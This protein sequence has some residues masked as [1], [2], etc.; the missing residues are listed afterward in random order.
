MSQEALGASAS[1][2]QKDHKSSEGKCWHLLGDT[3]PSH[4][5]ACSLTINALVQFGLDLRAALVCRL[6]TVDVH[7]SVLLV[8]STR[9]CGGLENVAG[10]GEECLAQKFQE[11]EVPYGAS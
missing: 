4:D 9:G 11:R 3:D 8:A 2:T 5:P 7:A 6:L 10:E 1:Q